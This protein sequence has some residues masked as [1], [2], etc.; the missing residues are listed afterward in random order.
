MALVASA[1]AFMVPTSKL[2]VRLTERIY[3]RLQ[4]QEQILHVGLGTR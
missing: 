2:Y 4:L 3:Q 1:F